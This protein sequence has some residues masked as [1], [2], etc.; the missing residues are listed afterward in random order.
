M[1]SAGTTKHLYFLRSPNHIEIGNN[2]ATSLVEKLTMSNSEPLRYDCM[3]P[4]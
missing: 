2:N 4:N 3:D 1:G